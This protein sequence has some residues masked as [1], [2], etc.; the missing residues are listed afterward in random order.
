MKQ[1]ITILFFFATT[2]AFAQFSEL[3]RFNS[4]GM[5]S[6]QW[7]TSIPTSSMTDFVGNKSYTGINIDYKHCYQHNII[8]GA[9]TG[10]DYFYENRLNVIKEGV[11]NTITLQHIKHKVNIIPLLLIVDYMVKSD[12]VIPYIG[13]GIGGYYINRAILQD[14]VSIESNNS[15]QFGVSP[16]LGITI[17]SIMNKFGFSISTKYNYTLGT[18]NAPSYSWFNFSIGASFMY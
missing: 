4:G 15:F 14:N 11:D 6:V 5:I 13:I 16:E 18:K 1:L 7:D 9:R 12:K 3:L 2:S 10:W 17:P 8:L